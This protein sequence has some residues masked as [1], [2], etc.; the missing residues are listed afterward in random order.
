MQVLMQQQPAIN[1]DGRRPVVLTQSIIVSVVDLSSTIS[2]YAVV[3]HRLW[4][5]PI[6]VTSICVIIILKREKCI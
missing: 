5:S 6:T 3:D 4:V 1:H 2:T